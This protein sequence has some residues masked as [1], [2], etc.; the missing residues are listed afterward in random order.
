MEPYANWGALDEIANKLVVLAGVAPAACVAVARRTGVK[1]RFGVGAAGRHSVSDAR[2]VTAHTVFDLAS[3]S[4][5]FVAL[6]AARLAQQG[7]LPLN[8]P[9]GNWLPE[10]GATETAEV[11]IELL[12]SHRAGLEAHRKLF[13][14]LRERRSFFRSSALLEAARAR[15]PDCTGR[16]PEAGF[17]PVYSDLGYILAGEAIS[18]AGGSPLDELVARQVCFPLGLDAGSTRQWL[19]RC[20][21][22]LAR[23]APTEIVA[24]RGGELVAVVHDDNAW[25]LGGHGIAGHAG[26]FAD[27]GAVARL[28]AAVLDAQ[29]G[30][31]DDWLTAASLEPILRSRPGGSLRAGFDGKSGST[32][33]AGSA[34]GPRSFGHLG[35]TGTSVWCDPDAELV[36]VLLSNRVNTDQDRSH[37]SQARPRL[38]TALH[39]AARRLL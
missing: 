23:V 4:K 30:R 15:R 16:P 3:V 18:R 19:A 9:V 35:F 37:I 21:D 17:A 10:I 26:L 5:P 22:F 39:E 31:F 12:L 36:T 34:S 33:A 32:S 14:A 6:T 11:A 38:H 7:Q 28:G 13:R 1:W 24:W 27:A 20:P 2:A 8:S 29:A 25:A